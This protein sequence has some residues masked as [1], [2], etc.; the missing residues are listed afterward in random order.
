MQ[1]PPD[2]SHTSPHIV[3][4]TLAG[5]KWRHVVGFGSKKQSSFLTAGLSADPFKFLAQYFAQSFFQFFRSL[6]DVIT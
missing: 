4:C 6:F 2:A 5:R 3:G 1:K